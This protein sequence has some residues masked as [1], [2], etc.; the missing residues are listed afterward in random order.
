MFKLNIKLM[1]EN[2][3]NVKSRK[4]VLMM[5]NNLALLG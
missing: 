1:W 3:A 5:K 4:W 2:E